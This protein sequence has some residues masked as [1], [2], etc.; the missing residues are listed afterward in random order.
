MEGLVVLKLE[1]RQTALFTFGFLYQR[2]SS[3]HAAMMMTIR[4]GQ[5]GR[6][7]QTIDIRQGNGAG[8]EGGR[9]TLLPSYI[10]SCIPLKRL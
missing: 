8:G 1:G 5:W 9:N 2:G 10:I 4:A 3:L 6:G 7:V